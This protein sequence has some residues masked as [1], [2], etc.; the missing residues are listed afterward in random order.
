MNMTK[1]GHHS[2]WPGVRGRNGGHSNAPLGVPLQL[3]LLGESAFFAGS[4]CIDGCYDPAS[5]SPP[6]DGP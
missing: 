4:I 3:T 6:Q 1:S 2:I 5:C